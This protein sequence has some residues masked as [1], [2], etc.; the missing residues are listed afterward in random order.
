MA[1]SGSLC[2]VASSCAG[3]ALASASALTA[4]HIEIALDLIHD[5]LVDR[6]PGRRRCGAEPSPAG[7]R[8]RADATCEVQGL[9]GV[10]ATLTGAEKPLSDRLLLAFDGSDDARRAA[11]WALDLAAARG[12]V[13]VEIVHA[14][15]LP[16]LPVGGPEGT[17]AA[18]L[19]A[20][21]S[22]LRALA[23]AERE[24]FA[25]RGV[26]ASVHLRR[27]MPAE[28][29][30]ERA[31]ETAAA[32]IVVGQHGEGP[33][34]LRLGSTSAAVA[35][36]AAAPVAVVRGEPR[37]APPRR[38][39]LALDGSAPSEAAARAVARWAPAATVTAVT[40]RSGEPG[41][42]R[43][44]VERLL[45]QAGFAAGRREVAVLE[46]DAAAAILDLCEARPVDLV[47]VGRRGLSRLHELLLGSVSSRLIERAPCPVLVAH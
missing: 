31:Q 41:P 28:T 39:L 12:G 35:R 18:F 11:R 37:D 4:Q 19:E 22:A 2:A 7:V 10:S 21:E 16:P 27:W 6:I 26:A 3:S 20:H 25:E 44:A 46:G 5:L 23:E 14:L 13:E 42:T 33:R 40:V 29:L 45:E 32:L 9:Q 1:P 38:V 43:E 15:A 17:A 24:R 34:H 30:I 47:A 8:K 36:S